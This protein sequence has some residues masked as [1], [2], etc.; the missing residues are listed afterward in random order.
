MASNFGELVLLV[1]DHHIP[2]RS[3]SIPPQF[4]RMLVPGKMQHVIC[5]GNLGGGG[6]NYYESEEYQR[7][8]ELVGGASANVHCVAGE[9]DFLSS[10][11]A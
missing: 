10:F 11:A 9:Y 1:G 3:D 2:F 5:T 7:L 8:K 6:D 4:T